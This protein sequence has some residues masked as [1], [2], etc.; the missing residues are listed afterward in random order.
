MKNFCFAASLI[1]FLLLFPLG[2]QPGSA[3]GMVS[4]PQ[5]DPDLWLSTQLKAHSPAYSGCG[6]IIAPII[7][8]EYEQRVVDLV[9]QA[10]AEIDLP[11]L[12]R[13]ESL[14]QAARYQTTDMGQDNYFDHDTYDRVA[15]ELVY[16]CNTWE[17]IATY[18]SGANAENAGAGYETPEAVM[19]GWM[20]SQ[21]HRDNILNDYSREIGV[22]YF[23]GSGDFYH[24]W[25]QDFGARSEVY[26]LVINREAT[27]TDSRS[28][29]VYIY[30]EDLWQ[31]MRLRNE[32]GDWSAWRPFQ[33]NLDW[34][35]SAGIGEHAVSAE[36]RAGS[37][38]VASSD[39]IY[40]ASAGSPPGL[41]NLPDS[42]AFT[43]SIPDQEL[44][45][46]S[47][48]VTPLNVGNE[49]PLSWEV[50][51]QGTF[52]TVEPLQGTTPES[53]TITPTDFD[54]DKPNIYTSTITITVVNPAGTASSPHIITLTLRVV[55]TQI[56]QTY[57]PGVQNRQSQM[58]ANSAGKNNE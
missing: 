45:P 58:E 4:T 32:A 8:A 33:A 7:N 13:T 9:N 18:Y 44:L 20:D 2:G 28:V 11:P 36:L 41:G 30:G 42:L 35:L 53:I 46:A 49:D 1:F 51:A 52:F 31:E 5:A 24:Y 19:A 25:I 54:R 55:D 23:A 27:T 10:R 47:Q 50:T 15:G 14:D 17:R 21:G 6:D 22:G 34:Q 29:S 16:V 12:K 26:P 40:L 56:F 39:T 48:Q 3:R 43:Y 38:T 37:Q 57:L